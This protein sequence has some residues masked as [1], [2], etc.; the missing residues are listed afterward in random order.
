[1]VVV[2]PRKAR[3]S[4][5][6]N[7]P[8]DFILKWQ[9]SGPKP[10]VRRPITACQACRIARV[11]CDNQPQ[12]ERCLSRNIVCRYTT[13]GALD[14]PLPSKPSS[15]TDAAQPIA[16]LPTTR[17]EIPVDLGTT[18]ATN[19]HSMGTTTYDEAF[20]AMAD[21][22]PDAGDQALDDLTWLPMDTNLNVGYLLFRG[23]YYD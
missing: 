18:D 9:S 22:S 20:E 7:I 21:W 8:H 12:C 23:Y 13:L 6:S 19:L 2:N 1:M 11:K 4:R 5:K 3:G 16:P 15:A 17:A 14:T 10:L